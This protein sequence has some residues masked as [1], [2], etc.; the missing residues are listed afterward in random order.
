LRRVPGYRYI[1]EKGAKA[2]AGVERCDYEA[3]KAGAQRYREQWEDL[4]K[5]GK[6]AA[7]I[8]ELLQQDRPPP[9]WRREQAARVLQGH[10]TAN[11]LAEQIAATSDEAFREQVE[12]G[13]ARLAAGKESNVPWKVEQ[14]QVFNPPAA[15]GYARL[16]PDSTDRNDST[17]DAWADPLAEWLRIRG[18]YRVATP[19]FLGSKGEHIRL[20]VPVPGDISLSA[21]A[22]VADELLSAGIPR[23]TAVKLDALAVLALTRLLVEHCA[24]NQAAAAAGPPLLRLAGRR[25]SSAITGVEI[26]HY[27]SLGQ[28]R[29]VGTLQR[30]ALPG[31]FAIEG[32]EDA[33]DWQAI[34]QEHTAAVRGLD[35]QHSDEIGILV[36]YRRFLQSPGEEGDDNVAAHFLE[37]LGQYGCFYM[38]ALDQ[39][40]NVRQF[41]RTN[42]RRVLLGMTNT[43]TSILDDPGFIA[44]ADAVRRATVSAQ[45]RKAMG[46]RDLREIR[47]DLLPELRRK[48]SL[49][50]DDLMLVV[51]KFVSLYNQENAQRREARRQA[52]RNVTTEEFHAFAALVQQHGA[53]KVGALLSAYGTCREP[54]EPAAEPELTEG[55]PDAAEG[56]AAE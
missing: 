21:L 54:R 42:V 31:W 7:E 4:R 22:T 10:L 27:Q 11:K 1:V 45:A 12:G 19:Y 14:V 3:E 55:E 44:I 35:D 2:P 49:K 32:P 37:F 16:K 17:A 41:L 56:E 30:L 33:R 46:H 36:A 15:K 20:I 23:H 18:Y 6:P 28:S 50:D 8:R 5:D 38:R 43:Y 39:K 34:L 9:A 47:Y 40:R 51:S 48:S 13:L 29:A 53:E 26:T 25:P 52:H 24:E